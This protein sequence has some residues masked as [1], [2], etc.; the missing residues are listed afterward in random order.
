MT[1]RVQM[2]SRYLPVTRLS[3]DVLL[4]LRLYYDSPTE[5][6]DID[7]DIQ[8]LSEFPERLSG[9]YRAEWE[10]FVKRQVAK[11]I[12]HDD[13]TPVSDVIETIMADLER[14]Y[15]GDPRFSRLLEQVRRAEA[16]EQSDKAKVF[17][18]PL[19]RQLMALLLPITTLPPKPPKK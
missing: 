4:A 19:R 3:I 6:V 11:Q 13:A 14:M 18:T 8:E 1:S 2:L 10:S 9:S 7:K 16:I 15:D 17:P 5:R 12:L